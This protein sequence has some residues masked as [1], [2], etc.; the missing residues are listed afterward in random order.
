MKSEGPRALYYRALLL[1]VQKYP[2][3]SRIRVPGTPRDLPYTCVPMSTHPCFPGKNGHHNCSAPAQLPALENHA[4]KRK[5]SP[6]NSYKVTTIP[7][8]SFNFLL[9]LLKL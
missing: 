3:H 5:A 7:F 8:N 2:T 1:T 4:L 9:L 6:P